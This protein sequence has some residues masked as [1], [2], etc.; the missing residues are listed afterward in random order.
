[1]AENSDTSNDEADEMKALI[2]HQLLSVAD[3]TSASLRETSAFGRD[4][5]TGVEQAAAGADL[6][7]LVR[8]MIERTAEVERKLAETCME[9]ERLRHD[10]DAARDDAS[11]DALTNL[12]NRRAIDGQ[13]KI[14]LGEKQN[15]AV[16]F[17][18]ID[19]FKAIN[20]RFGHAVGDRVLKSVAETLAQTVDPN[21]V[22]RYGGEEFVVLFPGMDG[23]S[24][25]DLIEKAR[26]ALSERT[27]RVRETDELIGMVTFSAGIATTDWDP[28]AAL[29]EADLLLYDAKNNGRNRTVYRSVL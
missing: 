25:F 23:Q 7:T 26:R 8:G 2:R 12:P 27:L 4:L 5:A 24:A 15:L 28:E 29:R 22:A 21:T 6:I 20:D 11:R 10:L 13:I 3:L 14:M 1:V 16:A 18:D 19:H 17:C 9:T